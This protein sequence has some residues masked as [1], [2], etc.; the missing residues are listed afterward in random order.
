[1]TVPFEQAEEMLKLGYALT[2]HKAQGTEYDLVLLPIV[3]SHGK[4]ILQRN[5]LYTAITRAKKK[6]ILFGQGGAVVDA[7]ENDKIQ[8]RNT[9][10]GERVKLWMS[11]EGTSLQQLFSSVDDCLNAKTLKRLLL[12]E[13]KASS[14]PGTASQSYSDPTES[15]ETDD[16]CL[17]A[18]PSSKRRKNIS[19]E[20]ALGA[21]DM[22]AADAGLMPEKTE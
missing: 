12:C 10:L 22:E 15:E 7:I 16:E 5:L 14:E 11:G 21:L 13:E 1:M 19:L 2:V 9:L 20:Q 17:K 18:P 8:E 6:V 3:K 4:K